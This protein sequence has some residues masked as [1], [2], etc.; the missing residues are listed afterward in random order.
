MAIKINVG[1]LREGE[2]TIDF[3]TDTNELGLDSSLIKDKL[4]I[5]IDLN[6]VTHQIDMKIS[7]VYTAN[8][9]CDKCIEIFEKKI[10][11]NFEL[12]LV[13][14]VNLEV[15]FSVLISSKSHSLKS[16]NMPSLKEIYQ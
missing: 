11:S 4:H 5:S 7:L 9:V 16:S 8:L 2:Q 10:N 6:K 12:V 15:G 1:T 14:Y 3:I 13:L